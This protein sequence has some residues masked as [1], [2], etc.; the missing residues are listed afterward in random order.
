M[1]PTPNDSCYSN[2]VNKR[3]SFSIRNNLKIFTNLK[4]L[5][6][7]TRFGSEV[8]SRSSYG[9]ADIISIK[10]HPLKYSFAISFLSYINS[11]LNNKIAYFS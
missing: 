2:I 3:L 4:N 11:P 10:N 7:L 1:K 9:K 8:I 6:K 5:K